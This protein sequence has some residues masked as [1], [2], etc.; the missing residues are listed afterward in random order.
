MTS[1]DKIKRVKS[2][3]IL[4]LKPVNVIRVTTHD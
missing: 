2:V 4:Y 3:G 1:N